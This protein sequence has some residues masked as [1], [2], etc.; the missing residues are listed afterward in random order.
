MKAK[1]YPLPKRFNVALSDK[2][3]KNLRRLNAKYGYSNNYLLTIILESLDAI[4]DSDELAKAFT[5]FK[6]E[7]GSPRPGSMRKR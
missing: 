5:T 2:A 7:Y 4:A 3:Y 6:S 1:R